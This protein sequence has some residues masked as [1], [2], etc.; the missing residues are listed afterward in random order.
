[1]RA[2][3]FLSLIILVGSLITGTASAADQIDTSNILIM[4]YYDTGVYSMRQGLVLDMGFWSGK[5]QGL[6]GLQGLLNEKGEEHKWGIHRIGG[7]VWQI[8]I[9]Q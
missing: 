7:M 5:D 6:Q 1:M 8:C 3:V 9:Q 2:I 4:A